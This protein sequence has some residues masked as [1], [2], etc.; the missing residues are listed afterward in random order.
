V[1][2]L[3]YEQGI[4]LKLVW[5]LSYS[6]LKSKFL[7]DFVFIC[8]CLN[9]QFPDFFKVQ[10]MSGGHV[11]LFISQMAVMIQNWTK[12]APLQNDDFDTIVVSFE[13]IKW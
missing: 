10:F 2:S 12:R 6:S 3:F 13:R 5:G 11:Y 9:Q 8:A 7:R 1:Q 4:T